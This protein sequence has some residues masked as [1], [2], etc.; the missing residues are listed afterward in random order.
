VPLRWAVKA[1]K[2]TKTGKALVWIWLLHT[3]W[4]TKS[5]TFPLAN[6]KLREAGVNRETKRRALRELEAEGLINVERQHGKSSIVT[7]IE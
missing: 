1:A 2:A 6:G 7:L 4:K 5:A 3:R